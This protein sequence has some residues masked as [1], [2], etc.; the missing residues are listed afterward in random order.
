M[1]VTESFATA[2]VRR[3]LEAA[4]VLC[5]GVEVGID[6]VQVEV[7]C[8][9]ERHLRLRGE[10]IP[11]F[12][13]LSRFW[14]TSDGWVRTH[15][16]YP[17]HQAALV[18]ALKVDSVEPEVVAKAVAELPAQVVE[19][20]VYAGGGLAVAVRE[21]AEWQQLTPTRQPLVATTVLGD[22]PSRWHGRLRILDLTRV[23]AGPVA[24]RLLGALG[25][26]VLRLDPPAR[27]ELP[28][29]RLDGL[30]G[31]RSAL[32]D[33]A[34]PA[35]LQRLH[36]LLEGADVV[37]QGF[38]PGALS[39][40]GLAP[41]QLADRHPGLV[42]VTLSAWG[43]AIGWDSRRGF[44]SL[45][46]AATGIALRHSPDRDRPGTLPCQLLDHSAGYL[47]A[48]AALE[49]VHRQR[50]DGGTHS[51]DVSLATVA[52]EVLRRP[53]PADMDPDPRPWQVQ[54]G[55]VSVVQPPGMLNGTPLTWSKPPA[56]YGGDR[57][58]WLP[59]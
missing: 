19:D 4:A 35:G 18:A 11:G 2:C 38:R 50:R 28:L 34:D 26:D 1:P 37:V 36:H 31:K 16:N 48:A 23:I 46:Q 59:D 29:H 24:T 41:Q 14:Q 12:A 47:M 49:G 7:V 25:H 27:P 43:Q 40:F 32:L 44:D 53:P 13:Q 30:L 22:A 57:P 55:A 6:P 20:R 54:L 3:A 58:D 5:G 33:A 51:A 42:V 45:V 10:S 15:A 56:T 8:R 21:A 52:A 17:W 39:R 9:S